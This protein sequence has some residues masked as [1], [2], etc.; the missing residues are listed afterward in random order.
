MF[1]SKINSFLKSSFLIGYVDNSFHYMKYTNYACYLNSRSNR[2]FCSSTTRKNTNVFGDLAYEKY[3]RVKMDEAEAKEEKFMESDAKVPKWKKYS[4][5]Q[6]CNLIKSHIAD[7]NLN[8][9][10]TVLDLAKENR[11]KL[12]AHMYNL[13]I[14]GFA[15][16]GFVEMCFKLYNKLKKDGLIPSQAVYNNLIN[17]CALTNNTDKAIWYLQ[18][19]REH[20]Y[21]KNVALNTTHYA[22]LVKAYA[23]HK[24]VNTAFEIADEAK[25]RGLLSE[26]LYV[27][28]FH[29]AISDKQEGLKYALALWHQMRKHGMKP[30]VIHYNLLFRAIRDTK[31]GKLKAN[32]FITPATPSS[33][34][35][36]ES[37]GRP[38]LLASPPVLSR[39][40]LSFVEDD[41]NK[42][43]NLIKQD[44]ESLIS[45]NLDQILI[46][47]KLILFGGAEKLLERM[48]DDN[49]TPNTK[50]LT[51]LM[52]LL[53]N[54]LEAENQFLKYINKYDME[55]DISF[56]NMLIKKRCFRKQYMAA[57]D[58]LNE[59]QRCNLE[60]NIM[61][62]GVLALACPKLE[63]GIELLEQMSILGLQPNV[64]VVGALIRSA[65]YRKDF[66]YIKFMLNYILEN[67]IKPSHNIFKILENFEQLVLEEL[68]D[69]NRY[70]RHYV[71]ELGKNYNGYKLLYDEWKETMQKKNNG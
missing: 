30:T 45:E 36:F 39:P 8:L 7:G 21:Q 54:S 58:I 47:N 14:Y 67:D 4:H 3:E 32:D 34:I 1:S 44:I 69:M 27:A 11:D 64:T 71:R 16:Q 18:N 19:L 17:A 43:E 33:Q 13:L 12:S 10:L 65:C 57:K 5:G 38:D 22:T 35:V 6:Y 68:K 51:I 50:T 48:K 53:P 9:A 28:L 52:E 40:L 62:F 42:S 24:Q 59:V 26:D 20:F 29:A 15:Q 2:N 25:D 60:P 70:H 46:S 31:F 41:K 23:W 63:H 55:V 61:T 66:E 49:V 37:A 56:F